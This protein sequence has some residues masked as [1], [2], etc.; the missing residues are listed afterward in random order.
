[1]DG[2][3]GRGREGGGRTEDVDE[4]EDHGD[5]LRDETEHKPDRHHFEHQLSHIPACKPTHIV[6][7]KTQG[8]APD[9]GP[10]G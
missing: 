7:G 5:D 6:V 1:M 4:R 9:A 2:W 10:R 8:D 3:G